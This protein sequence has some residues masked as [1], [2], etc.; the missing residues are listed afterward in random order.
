M[1]VSGS[2]SH[3][4]R[5]DSTLVPASSAPVAMASSIIPALSVSLCALAFVLYCS[6]ADAQADLALDCCLTVSPKTIPKHLLLTYRKQ[7]KGDGCPLDA[8]VFITRRGRSLCAPPAAEKQ[9]VKEHIKFLVSRLKKCKETKFSEN[10][11][12]ALKNLSE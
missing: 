1:R 6:P 9:W 4:N 5:T 3:L 10:R 2:S 12:H 7:F 11:C 8:V